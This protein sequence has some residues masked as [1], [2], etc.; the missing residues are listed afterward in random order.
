[1]ADPKGA[2]TGAPSQT[3]IPDFVG[4]AIDQLITIESKNLG[5]PHNVVRTM[6]DA[7]RKL[8]GDRPIAMVAAERL[9]AVVKP[10]DTVL[11]LTG[12]GYPPTLPQGE[13]DGPPGAVSLARAL[14]K[15]LGAVPVYVS[16]A[17]HVAPII[18][19]SEAAHLM[20]R[21]FVHARD[22]HLGAALEV[23]PTDQT[24]VSGWV[25][26]L[27]AE[28]KPVAI[29]SAERLGP[30]EGG[31]V[32]NA[33][34]QRWSGPKREIEFDVVDIS[35]VV[36]KGRDTGIL[37]IGIG[38]HGNEIGFDSIRAAVEEIMPNG[39]RL[40]TTVGTDIVLPVMMSNWG[41][42]GIEA[43]LAFLLETPELMHG[44]AAEE[45]ILKACLAAGGLEAMFCSTAFI[46][47][48]LEGETS[49]ACVQ[50]LR[51]IVR[52]A[53]EPKTAGLTH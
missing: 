24:A 11:I 39:S 25:A 48:G 35:E 8:T 40:C 5:M 14:Y 17:C 21:D 52:K 44:P 46:V 20:V 1:M 6:Y 38:D 41:C 12:A 34:G 32:H 47:D 16:E 10:G 22:R 50:M 28:T 49:M 42:Y 13:S 37:T 53:L 30:G 18:A 45:A 9:R 36:T 29:I 19:S 31:I 23:A 33:T 4:D 43:A 51:N 7:A 26:K 3:F 27:F 2:P 15:G